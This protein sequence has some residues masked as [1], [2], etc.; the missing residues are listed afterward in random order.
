[1]NSVL[2][3]QSQEQLND[4]L[5]QR[6]KVDER[7]ATFSSDLAEMKRRVSLPPE[8]ALVH[9]AVSS[10]FDFVQSQSS[11]ICDVAKRFLDCMAVAF[12]GNAEDA[13]SAK[14]FA[15]ATA[16]LT[17]LEEVFARIAVASNFEGL[18]AQVST[19]LR[20]S[21]SALAVLVPYSQ[22]IRF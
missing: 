9:D 2:S 19:S 3:A 7:Q 8:N 1:M 11:E 6:A 14:A 20:L 16:Q 15:Q 18:S 21:V 10:W 22:A 13:I 5:L 17:A 4:A 12:D